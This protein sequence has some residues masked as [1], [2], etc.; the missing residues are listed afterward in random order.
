MHF[1]SSIT[2]G[3]AQIALVREVKRG[4]KGL[5]HIGIVYVLK[6]GSHC[7]KLQR[8]RLFLN[9]SKKLLFFEYNL[10]QPALYSYTACF[11]LEF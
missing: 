2:I 8:L 9:G 10:Y 4:G 7:H 5:C 11:S 1:C 3:T 6:T